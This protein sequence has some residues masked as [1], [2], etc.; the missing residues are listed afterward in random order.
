MARIID[1]TRM[2]AGPFA[3]QILGDLGSEIIKV[4]A[5]RVGDYTRRTPPYYKGYS[6][7]YFSA[8][9]NKKSIIV[10]LKHPDGRQVILDLVKEADV[11]VENFRPGVMEKLGLEYHH[12][13]EANPA[14]IL[15]SINGF[16][17]QGPMRNKTS[18]DI[19]A[20]AM[21]GAMALTTNDGGDPIKPAIP[22]GDLG[23]GLY[24]ALGVVRALLERKITGKGQ[25][26]EVSLFDAVLAQSAHAGEQALLAGEPSEEPLR[27]VPNG[28]FAT[29]DGQ[30]AVA[31][32]TDAGWESLCRALDR[33][34]WLEDPCFG[35]MEERSKAASDIQAIVASALATH[36]SA[37]WLEVFAKG[38]VPAVPVS[39]MAD[40]F[41]DEDLADRHMTD[42][43]PHEVCGPLR[44]FGNPIQSEDRPFRD[45]ILSPPRHGQHTREVMEEVLSYDPDK[46]NDLMESKAICD[47]IPEPAI[48]G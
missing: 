15:V 2:L 34:G 48:K 36:S 28:I 5:E 14:I 17:G 42:A 37:H 6:A 22:L 39:R 13:Q 23:G 32:Y 20:Q 30:L 46:V 41:A 11:V 1:L 29:S 44:T 10:D 26:L 9:R 40:V 3:T 38:G 24:A 21:A 31:A 4:E 18:F 33:P 12:L 47:F 19:V 8:N 16:G 35:S 43:I 45:E 25:H 7:Y 27:L